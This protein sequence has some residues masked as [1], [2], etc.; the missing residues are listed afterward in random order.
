[1]RRTSIRILHL[2]RPRIV[3]V[4]VSKPPRKYMSIVVGVWEEEMS[5]KASVWGKAERIIDLLFS[6]GEYSCA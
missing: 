3:V 4:V 1:M 5:S 6:I 2:G